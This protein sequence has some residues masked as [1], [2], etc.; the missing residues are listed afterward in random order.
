L[1][2]V[3]VE[4][5]DDQLVVFAEG[6]PAAGG[7][8]GGQGHDVRHREL[9]LGERFQHLLTDCSGGADDSDLIGHDTSSFV[10]NARTIP[11]VSRFNYAGLG[12]FSSGVHG[13]HSNLP[14]N[15]LKNSADE[16]R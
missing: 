10:L 11:G 1:E 14:W 13:F 2:V 5:L 16:F 9:S 7:I 6:H 8:G 3:L 12:G 4:C 15:P